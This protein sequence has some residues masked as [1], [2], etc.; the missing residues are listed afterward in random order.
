[1]QVGAALGFSITHRA[2]S[3]PGASKSPV[4]DAVLWLYTAY[5]V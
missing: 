5:P 1:V 3:T 4:D 2:G